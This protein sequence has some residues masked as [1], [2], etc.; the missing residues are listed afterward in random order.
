[1]HIDDRESS[2]YKC[3]SLIEDL[4]AKLAYNCYAQYQVLVSDITYMLTLKF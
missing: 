3:L 1:M 2:I 4:F